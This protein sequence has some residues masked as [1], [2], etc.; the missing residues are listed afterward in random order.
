[1]PES[2]NQD[3]PEYKEIEDHKEA[4][5]AMKSYLENTI[6]QVE[7]KVN[8]EKAPKTMKVLENAKEILMDPKFME[9]KGVRSIVVQVA[10]VGHRSRTQNFF[11][12]KTEYVITT[13]D[14]MITAVRVNDGAYVDGTQFNELIELTKESGVTINEVYGDRAYFKKPILYKIKE[15]EATAYIPVRF[16]L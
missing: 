12:Y 10:R 11:G 3:I 14:R 4:K 16:L 15:L 9:Q 13:E 6:S 5:E 7:Q 8:I 1:M 2:I